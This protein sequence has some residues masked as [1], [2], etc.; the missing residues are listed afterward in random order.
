M[1][2]Y[3]LGQN[4]W[5]IIDESDATLPKESDD[6]ES[7]ATLPKESDDDLKKWN[8]KVEP[9]EKLVIAPANNDMVINYNHDWILDSGCSNHMTGINEKLHDVSEY[10]GNRMVVIANNL[11]LP[12]T[13]VAQED[14][15]K[16]TRKNEIAD[17]WHA[18]LGHVSY[19]KVREM[20]RKSTLKGLPQLKIR[21]ETICAGCQY[22][23]AHQCSFKE[24]Q[25]KTKVP[26]E[27]V[28]SEVFGLEKKPS[29][30]G[31]RYMITFI[32]DYSRYV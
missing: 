22:V 20:I 19:Q 13:H 11:K 2:F 16:K 27:L 28:H 24:S 7:D 4:L 1:K 23:K 25:F 5:E 10:K 3:F 17:L 12:I 8:V 31:L 18:R 9:E 14:Y 30:T 32:D 29:V 15:V 21:E 6:D 26:L